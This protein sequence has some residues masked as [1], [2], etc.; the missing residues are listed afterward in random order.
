MRRSMREGASRIC[1][2]SMRDLS[3][4][5][6]RCLAYEF[7]D[8]IL[9]LDDVDLVTPRHSAVSR[10]GEKV[11]EHLGRHLG[12]VAGLN[13][14][15]ERVRLER[16]YELFVVVCQFPRDLLALGALPGWR[17]RAGKAVL[18]LEEMWQHGLN[19]SKAHLALLA[20]FD[21]VFLNC[22]QTV[23]PLS[24]AIGRPVSYA[25]PGVDALLFSPW[26][27]LPERV[28]DVL[29]IGRRSL[30][31]HEA[32]RERKDFFYVYDT[33]TKDRVADA[34]QHRELL[35]SMI[36]RARYFIANKGKFN[37][38]DETVGQAEIGFRFVEGVAGGTIL[39]GD[40][41]TGDAWDRWFGWKDAAIRAPYDAP[42]IGALIDELDADPERIE[43]ARR[44]NVAHALRWHDWSHRWGTILE[45]A[46][47]EPRPALTAR[48]RRAT[49]FAATI[50]GADA[51][52]REPR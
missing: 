12:A 6:A 41:P 18:W 9:E 34:K 37:R 31:T 11:L 8:R 28:I 48:R 21:H 52:V 10:Y 29:N 20:R 2:V 51:A 23:E 43:R 49:E 40:H 33:I 30:V 15:L 35:A 38:S 26:P 19:D 47:I 39:L 32:L 5:V 14:G 3:S 24:R 44:A 45:T 25:P 46:G 22:K 17:E 50:D 4:A 13:P 36:K 1:L 42:G 7:E 16:D 27:D